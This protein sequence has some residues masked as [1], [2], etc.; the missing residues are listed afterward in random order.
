MI[1]WNWIIILDIYACVSIVHSR[2]C[3]TYKSIL[4]I[5][6]V[7]ASKLNIN[8]NTNNNNQKLETNNR[9]GYGRINN[10]INVSSFFSRNIF[11]LEANGVKTWC[12]IGTCYLPPQNKKS[13][14]KKIFNMANGIEMALVSY[15]IIN[16]NCKCL[17]K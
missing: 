15:C 7:S 5:I 11:Q 17:S 13:V 16:T 12:S 2:C 10:N 14:W 6:I 4:T 1:V 9:N 3:R 8:K